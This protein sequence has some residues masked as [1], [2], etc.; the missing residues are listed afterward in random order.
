MLGPWNMNAQYYGMLFG[1]KIGGCTIGDITAERVY[2][3]N[4]QLWKCFAM[5]LLSFYICHRGTNHFS[6]DARKKSN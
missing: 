2:N 3:E 5:D 1:W 4:G 6:Q